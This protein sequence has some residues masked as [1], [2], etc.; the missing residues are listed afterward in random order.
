MTLTLKN[1][2]LCLRVKHNLLSKELENK[3]MYAHKDMHT[4]KN[5]HAVLPPAR[6]PLVKLKGVRAFPHTCLR[7]PSRLL[8]F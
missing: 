6:G 4:H 5:T 1:F 2:V 8:S 3:N 7:F